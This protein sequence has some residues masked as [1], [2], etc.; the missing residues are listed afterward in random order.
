MAKPASGT[1]GSMGK[2]S[3]PTEQEMMVILATLL[4]P[5]LLRGPPVG[6]MGKM[7]KMAMI[8]S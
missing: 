1:G 5:R 6:P 8:L 7:S 4:L 3:E 2:V